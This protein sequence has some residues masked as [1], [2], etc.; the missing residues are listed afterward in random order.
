MRSIFFAFPQAKL[1]VTGERE[2]W[3]LERSKKM[4]TGV[5][6]KR[7]EI[8]RTYHI[9]K[10]VFYALAKLPGSPIKKIEGVGWALEADQ[11]KEFIR[12]YKNEEKNE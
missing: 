9:S 2:F 10:K 8:C 3:R 1:I 4:E 5:V 6:F 7:D 12:N 11:M